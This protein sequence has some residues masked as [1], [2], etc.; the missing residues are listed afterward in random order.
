MQHGAC[1]GIWKAR[2]DTIPSSLI[3]V[4]AWRAY[5]RLSQKF[6]LLRYD[7]FSHLTTEF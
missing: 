1:C 3:G 4:G 2:Q 5:Y 6:K 7:K